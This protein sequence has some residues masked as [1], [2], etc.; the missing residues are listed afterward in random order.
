MIGTALVLAATMAAPGSGFGLSVSPAV[1]TGPATS[2]ASF[3]IDDVGTTPLSLHMRVIEERP[4][5]SGAFWVPWKP[6]GEATLSPATF[7]LQPAHSRTVKVV[8]RSTDGL[9][10]RLAITA[11]AQQATVT[12]GAAV[13]PSVAAAYSVTGA[14]NPYPR[15]VVAVPVKPAP[16]FP[17]GVV[18]VGLLLAAVLAALVLAA[19]KLRITRR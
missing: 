4:A 6:Y 16:P 18:L 14:P 10:H 11:E 13:A 17:W 1:V 7:T 12:S 15:T 19:R 2:T 5:N 3:T 9:H 8:I